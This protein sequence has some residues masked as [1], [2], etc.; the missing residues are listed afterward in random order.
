MEKKD[1]IEWARKLA[2]GYRP[3]PEVVRQLSQID[4]IAIV[5]PTGVGKTTIIERLGLPYVLS[6][7]TRPMRDGEK[8]GKEYHFRADYVG[9]IKDI[10]E[11]RYTQFLVAHSGEFYGTRASSYPASGPAT[12]AVTATAIPLFRTLGFKRVLPIYILPPGY[13]E[14]MRR[15][16]TERAAEIQPRMMEAR[17]SLES[18]LQDP[19]YCFILNDDL[20]VAVDEVKAVIA[21][22]TI[23]EHRKTLAMESAD[24]LLGRLGTDVD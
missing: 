21:G 7:V 4:L 15:I 3:S 2:V 11:G 23:S 13:V 17:E 18:A 1:F 8:D 20:E 24:L 10:K 12:M 6:D 5:G 22:G 19:A 9:I 16:G 14:W